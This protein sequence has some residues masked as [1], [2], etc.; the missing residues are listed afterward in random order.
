M[1][2]ISPGRFVNQ[3]IAGTATAE[4]EINSEADSEVHVKAVRRHSPFPAGLG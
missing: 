1:K 3:A 4:A 2:A